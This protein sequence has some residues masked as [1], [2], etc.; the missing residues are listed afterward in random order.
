MTYLSGAYNNCDVLKVTVRIREQVFPRHVEAFRRS[1]DGHENLFR[2]STR[3]VVYRSNIIHQVT[4]VTIGIKE[5]I[6]RQTFQLYLQEDLDP[7]Q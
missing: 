5:N 2:D 3:H 4:I 1:P 7:V 6:I